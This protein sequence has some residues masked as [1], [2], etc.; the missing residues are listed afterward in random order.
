M[1]KTS[2]TISSNKNVKVTKTTRS[3]KKESSSKNTKKKN[4]AKS[5]NVK[6][7]YFAA[8]GRRKSAVCR[9]RLMIGTGKITVNQKDYK[10]YFPGEVWQGIIV[11]PLI[12][13]GNQKK[14]DISILSRGGGVNSQAEAARHG[15]SRALERLDGD[16]R[17]TLKKAGFLT[18]DPRE[19]E[20]K[21]YGLKR[22]RR[23]PQ[24]SKR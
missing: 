9:V 21:K 17:S 20:R 24:F 8:V 1:P 12:L 22:A 7:R 18:R 5:L 10:D 15:I 23:A 3:E 19:K 2:K 11:A 16:L 13:T 14:F 6:A 4:S